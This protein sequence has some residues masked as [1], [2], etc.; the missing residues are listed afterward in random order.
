MNDVEKEL[1]VLLSK[2][3]DE[4]RRGSKLTYAPVAA[5]PTMKKALGCL[6]YPTTLSSRTTDLTVEEHPFYAG[7]GATADFH[8]Q[9]IIF[10]YQRQI[11]VDITNVPY[12]L[13]CLQVL[14][15]GRKS[16]DLQTQAAIEASSDKISLKDIRNAYKDLGLDYN[17]T[18]LD[19]DTIIG[20]FQARVVDS[21]RQEQELRRA[22]H[23]IGRSRWSQKIEFVASKVVTNYEQA[24]LWLGA[25]EEITDEFL[26]S[27][28]SVKVDEKPADEPI[29]R[30]AIS[31]IA[32]HRNS[33]ALRKWLDTGEL[34]ESEMDVGYAYN[35]LGI[36]DRTIDDDT[37]LAAY[38][39]LALDTPS[40]LDDLKKA[41][42]AIAKSKESK[43]LQGFLNTGMVSS[44]HPLSEWPVG[45][46]NIGNTCYLNSLL[47]FYFTVQPL[48]DLVLD[49]EKYKMSIDAE[50][51]AGK[52]VG[53]RNVSLK[54]IQRA[55][56]FAYELQKLFK[57]MITAPKAQVTPEQELARLTLISSTNEESFRRKSVLSAHRPSLGEINGRPVV[58]PL[59]PPRF[60]PNHE[61][62]E[63]SGN[64]ALEPIDVGKSVEPIDNAGAETV[65][66]T[67][68]RDD[69]SE[70][71]LVEDPVVGENDTVMTDVVGKDEK[72]QQQL[73]LEDKENLPPSKTPSARASTPESPL[74]PLGDTS[75]SRTNEQQRPLSPIKEMNQDQNE[76][77]TKINA[78]PPNRP[79][80]FP[81]RPK[82]D[83]QKVIQEEINI[84]AQQ[85]VTEVIANVLF[86][87]QCAIKAEQVDETG[88]QL[89]R[90][91]K[92]FFGKQK[93][94]TT[95]VQ[96]SIRTKEEFISDIK[97]DVAS[98]P[99][100][101][102]A[103][104]DGAFDIQEVE[105]G[106]AYEPQY[107]T[108]SQIP[109]ILQVLVQRVQF[110]HQEKRP[111]KSNHHL[112]LKETIY[113]DRYV[114]ST[115]LDLMQRRRECW[116]WKKRLA[117][118]KKR[119][120]ELTTA[121]LGMSL[122]E[123][124]TSTT[125]Y[126]EQVATDDTATSFSEADLLEIS[127]N[128]IQ[129]LNKAGEETK[130]EVESIEREIKTLETSIN[131]QFSDLRNIPYR[132]Q[133]VFI[134]RGYV[135]SGHYW[136]YIRDFETNVWRKYNDGYVTEVEDTKEIFEQE[137]SDR[138]ATSYF[139]VYV[140]DELKDQLVNPICRDILEQPPESRDIIMEDA[141]VGH[142]TEEPGITD[143]RWEVSN[144]T[145][146][147]PQT[148]PSRGSQFE[149]DIIVSKASEVNAGY[150]GWDNRSAY[151]GRSW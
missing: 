101:I 26:I 46:E 34:G 18:L 121:H 15:E 113:M 119:R 118:Y 36:S 37:I 58:G 20:T 74:I 149:S 14:G 123:L 94:Y 66:D 63:M 44:E 147:P 114:D 41:L 65:I 137:V 31:L 57:S 69:S 93:S 80:P 130:Q 108:L 97:V 103:A 79:P 141:L 126:L 13:E 115:D 122:P 6:E 16:E 76:T 132:L 136:I 133:S 53:S 127:P 43:L 104:L 96:G 22:L 116:S 62:T 124:L 47:Q 54:E 85:D 29:A 131:S 84:G 39:Y 23:I 67:I 98:G 107:T 59:P 88:E 140:K 72:E 138:P 17:N 150:L 78:G 11:D 70:D 12:Y 52:R 90:I 49:F 50:T 125:G 45:L 9:L 135:S 111:Y 71:T 82:P 21:P 51:L 95:D 19:D 128:L 145:D 42:T 102:Y 109:P 1:L 77:A 38:N 4:E 142:A 60:L 87:L 99:R 92:L 5:M 110:D 100:D 10:A 106:G 55:Q 146:T 28:F 40:Q 32:E 91:K 48:R 105:V 120:M 151:S 30:Q 73:V 68:E 81:P 3:P 134:H 139:V 143:L 24:L 61:D 2:R 33:D 56:R 117:D 75:P 35:R 64:S 27:M 144:D 7:L 86:Q 8:D 112:E 148:S 83:D 89:D 129:H 25:G